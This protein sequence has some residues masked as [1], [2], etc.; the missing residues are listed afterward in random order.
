MA[1][2][3]TLAQLIERVRF[4]GDL[5][6]SRVASD[7]RI[8]EIV[9]RGIEGVWDLLLDTRPEQYITTTTLTTTPGSDSV[10]LPADFYR[11]RLVEI[12]DGSLYRPL[13]PHN[14]S[15]AWRYQ[16]GASTPARMTYRVE[17][18]TLRILPVPTQAWTLRVRYHKPATDLVSGADTFDGVNGYE[19]LV[20][21]RSIAL[22]RGG[23]EGMDSTWW[24]QEA[25]RLEADVRRSATPL[26][27]GEPF[28][29]SGRAGS[30][31]AYDLPWEAE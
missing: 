3:I 15:E 23:R 4:Q 13:K 8:T 11:L 20:I 10:A 25:A 16:L 6:N 29:L 22:L 24:D 19:D 5:E 30:S 9:N 1:K 18:D 14:V 7:A 27:A 2:T 12:F 28:A 26:D 17:S 31:W 21:A